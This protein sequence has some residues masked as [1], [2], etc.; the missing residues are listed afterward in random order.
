M[1]GAED[2]PHPPFARHSPQRA[3]LAGWSLLIACSPSHVVSEIDV[4]AS[5]CCVAVWLV[6]PFYAGRRCGDK[7]GRGGLTHISCAYACSSSTR[8]AS[9]RAW[10]AGCG[11]QSGPGEDR[12]PAGFPVGARPRRCRRSL[13]RLRDWSACVQSGGETVQVGG[14][15]ASLVPIVC[16]NGAGPVTSVGRGCVTVGSALLR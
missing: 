10:L 15:F 4:M 5:S 1:L 13:S 2:Q 8:F 11:E 16:S 3:L 14:G 9:G 7:D 6:R 12:G